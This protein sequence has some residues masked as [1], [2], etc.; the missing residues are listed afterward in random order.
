MKYENNSNKLFGC[1]TVVFF[2]DFWQILPVISK[3]TWVVIV[4][5]SLN[6]SYLWSLLRVYK[7]KKN[8]WLY[9]E[10]VT[11]SENVEITTSN[12]WFYIL[13]MDPSMIILKMSLLNCLLIYASHHPVT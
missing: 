5:T 7:L 10:R 6:F 9:S 4:D 8:M 3:G 12:K 13:R 2:G 1:L 11:N